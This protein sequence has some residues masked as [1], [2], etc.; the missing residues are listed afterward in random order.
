LKRDKNII[1]KEKLKTVEIYSDNNLVFPNEIGGYIDSRN[2]TE[3]YGVILKR[4]HIPY[5]KFYALRYTYT[6]RLIESGVSLKMVQVLL[7]YSSMDIIDS[8]YIHVLQKN[9]GCR[10]FKLLSIGNI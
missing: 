8:I 2:L 1:T 7:G 9:K 3:R 6:T 4:A 5:R 10:C